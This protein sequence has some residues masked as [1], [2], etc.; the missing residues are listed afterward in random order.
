MTM[1]RFAILGAGHGAAVYLP[2]LESLG[3]S[4]VILAARTPRQGLSVAQGTDWRAAIKRADVDA[5]VIALPP[6]LQR[7]AVLAVAAA[8]KPFICEKPAGMHADDTQ[9]MLAAAEGITH[10]V[11]YQ[12][13]YEPAFRRLR[14]A[15]ADQTVGTVERIDIDW[16]TGGAQNRARPWSWRNNAAEGGGVVLNFSTHT[17]DYLRW[18]CG[19]LTLLGSASRILVPNRVDQSGRTRVVTAPDMCDFLL[20]FGTTGIASIRLTNLALQPSGHR[21]T[22][23]G[24]QGTVELWHRPPFRDSDM[25]FSVIDAMGKLDQVSGSALGMAPAGSD[26]R[27]A[28]TK[29][30]V[31]EFVQAVNGVETPDLPNLH[32]ALAV[33]QLI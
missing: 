24:S 18:M 8:G 12:F 4:C 30:L 7:E 16:C 31:A 26:S 20:G 23:R 1:M 6:D 15:I 21:V 29:S 33:Q 17:I 9:V 32:D 3:H 27:T 14:R 10:A 28:S 11:G 5:V 2:A 25:T 22:V 13:R 19:D